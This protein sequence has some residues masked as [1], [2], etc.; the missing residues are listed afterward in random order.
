MFLG[1]S[2]KQNRISP[3]VVWDVS[4]FTHWLSDQATWKVYFP[5]WWGLGPPLGLQC[6]GSLGTSYLGQVVSIGNSSMQTMGRR[7]WAPESHCCS[8]S[9]MAA[10]SLHG[11][12]VWI[13]KVNLSCRRVWLLP[14]PMTWWARWGW[15]SG[16]LAPYS[17]TQGSWPKGFKCMERSW[18][19]SYSGEMFWAI[20]SLSIC[21]WKQ[22][23]PKT[24]AC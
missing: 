18:N 16:L 1:F 12:F 21:R 15:I 23:F 10:S 24:K 2:V 11:A 4:S 13:R 9:F 14:G 20:N 3:L 8:R 17:G 7:W 22:R 6:C 5:C 19:E